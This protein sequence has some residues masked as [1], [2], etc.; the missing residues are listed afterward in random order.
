MSSPT[1]L[2]NSILDLRRKLHQ[3]LTIPLLSYQN[4]HW[5]LIWVLA[6]LCLSLFVV[7]RPFQCALKGPT[8]PQS[9]CHVI[10]GQ[11]TPLVLFRRG[12]FYC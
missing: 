4:A 9:C 2:Q 10:N 11:L 1:S 7:G 5:K 3:F 8:V 12:P 6:S